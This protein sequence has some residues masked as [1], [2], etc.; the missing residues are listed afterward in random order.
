MEIDSICA[1][2]FEA[3]TM[4]NCLQ[5]LPNDHLMDGFSGA[6]VRAGELDF[7]QGKSQSRRRDAGAT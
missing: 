7:S 5:P 2:Q 3:R 1:K 6:G 4:E